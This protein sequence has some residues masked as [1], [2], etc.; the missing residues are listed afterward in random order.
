MTGTR[1]IEI[2]D[3][4][5][6]DGCQAEDIAF[7][8][9][10]KLRIT[11]RLDEFG[12]RYIE[13]GWPGSNP[14]DEAFFK[15][16]Q[17]LHLKQAQI[18]AF[19]ATRRAGTKGSDDQNLKMLLQ[20]ET[21]VVT[22]VGKTWGLHVRD[23]LRISQV[24]NFQVIH[25]SISFLKR[26][27]KKVIFDAEHFFDGF[28]D[29]VEFAVKC[30]RVAAEA[31]A[32]LIC[33]CD[34][35]GGR[36][37]HEIAAAVDA[38]RQAVDTP[39]GIHCHNDSE[40]AVA[41]SLTA[42][43]HG[44]TQVQGTVNGI[45]ERCGNVNLCSVI[46]NLQLKMNYKVVNPAQLRRL[47]ELSH[48]VWE[49]ANLEPNKRQPFVG[50]SAFAHKGGLH[51]AAVQKNPLTYEH[52]DPTVVG[53]RQRVLVSDL[54]GR[55]NILYKAQEFGVDVETVKPA[56]KLVLAEVKE[57]ENKGFQFE[58][59]EASFELLMQKGL[60]GKVR[61]FRLIGFRVIDEKRKEDEP[62]LSEATIMIEGPDGGIEHTAATGNGPVNALDRALRKALRQFYPQIDEVE[63]LDYK[64]RVLGGGEG[65][66][67]TV[68][69]LIE[70]GDGHERWGTVG[71]SP[72]VIEASWQALVDSIEYKLYK[73]R[74]RQR[75]KHSSTPVTPQA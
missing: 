48:F 35:N 21:P 11:E 61:S 49:L 4:T 72:N 31:G 26:H 22:I 17:K 19:G 47:R 65:T 54:S 8:V 59:A 3:T 50:L 10:D 70:S 20:A 15:A 23:D 27:A 39:L 33:M 16:A 7:T 1:H 55:S 46:A 68:R 58:G 67:A 75:G 9:E 73:D 2:Y 71:V 34:T 74:K 63:L 42:V 18:A 51:V 30:C 36:L 53:N 64:V 56:V 62:P 69:V 28:H 44:V 52:I 45:G 41:N 40:L 12:V 5:L 29:N 24:Q 57:L 14:R 32:D 6:R 37:P 66:G 25:D 43:Q 13:G 60:N 38:V